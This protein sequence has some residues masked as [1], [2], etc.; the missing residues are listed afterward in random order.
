MNEHIQIL[1][2]SKRDRN[3]QQRR[4]I[5]QQKSKIM[6]CEEFILYLQF[7]EKR[8]NGLY[9]EEIKLNGIKNAKMIFNQYRKIGDNIGLFRLSLKGLIEGKEQKIIG[10]KF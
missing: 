4:F 6:N 5:D 2:A 7:N 3:R 1:E 8:S 10:V 9:L